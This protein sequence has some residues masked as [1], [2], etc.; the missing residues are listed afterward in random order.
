[1]S[2][3][4]KLAHQIS[5]NAENPPRQLFSVSITRAGDVDEFL[6][7]IRGYHVRLMQ[8]EKGPLVAEA[9]QTQLA[10][11]LFT[12][13]QY[14]RAVVHSG[15][16]PSGKITFAIGLSE[17]PILTQGVRFGPHDLLSL[18]PGS[19]IDIVSQAS[20]GLAA[21]SFPVDLVRET[22]GL[23]GL[24]PITH[25]STSL[26]FGLEPKKAD[27]LRATFSSF[28]N[29]AVAT[30]L[31]EPAA[32]TWALTKQDSLL[33]FLLHCTSDT[34][35]KPKPVS[36]GERARV[37][38]AALTAIK[39]S[40]EDVITVGDLCRIARA[41]ERTLDYAFA[42]RFGLSPA[43]YMKARRLNA[44]RNDLCREHEPQMKIADIANKRGFWH[45]GQ[46]ARDYQTWFGELPS[47]TYERRHRTTFARFK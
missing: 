26:V 3:F 8:I 27:L 12:A 17:V 29:E 6:E 46:F 47:E 19:E 41:S 11:V 45:L 31:N 24:T 34:S 9:V 39:D 21:A 32:T 25:P 23:L 30:P 10:G 7:S 44:A 40:A 15:E 36:N 35:P 28:L 14:Q 2:F 20:C 33:R 1:M 42:E 16:P 4:D 38:K 13:T 37:L 5:A 22:A 43:Q 18:T